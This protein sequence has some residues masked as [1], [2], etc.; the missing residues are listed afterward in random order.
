MGIYIYMYT[1][2]TGFKPFE[3]VRQI[4]H[5]TLFAKGGMTYQDMTTPG[6]GCSILLGV[7]NEGEDFEDFE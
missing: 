5:K 1:I 4:I 3:W 7:I 6:S 2:Y